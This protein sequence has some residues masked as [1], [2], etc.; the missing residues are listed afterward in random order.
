MAQLIDLLRCD[1]TSVYF[2]ILP[3][4]GL[5]VLLWGRNVLQC[6]W[7]VIVSL[8]ANA[9]DYSNKTSL[10]IQVYVLVSYKI[11]KSCWSSHL[12]CR[13]AIRLAPSSQ[14]LQYISAPQR[15]AAAVRKYTNVTSQRKKVYNF[16][17]CI[18]FLMRVNLLCS[19]M[20]SYACSQ[21]TPEFR[22]D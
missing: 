11:C 7:L 15:V 19:P 16:K 12:R 8:F 5:R 17:A 2:R 21:L 4:G 1:V 10:H 18:I 22:L 3:C 9:S 6:M 13:R 20:G 14:S